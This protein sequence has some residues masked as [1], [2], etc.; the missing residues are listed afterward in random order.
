MTARQFPLISVNFSSYFPSLY[1][2]V[3]ARYRKTGKTDVK[4]EKDDDDDDDD[5]LES[6]LIVRAGAVSLS[7]L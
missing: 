1:L 5:A 2:T 4:S 3:Q 7:K 6:V